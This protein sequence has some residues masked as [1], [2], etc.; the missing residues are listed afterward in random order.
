MAGRLTKAGIIMRELG[1]CGLDHVKDQ[2]RTIV[3]RGF[4]S[5]DPEI[6]RWLRKYS[7]QDCGPESA[8]NT[9]SLKDLV[10]DVLP[11]SVGLL[12]RQHCAGVDSL[13][14]LRLYFKIQ[15]MALATTR[16]S[17]E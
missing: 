7:G 1:R 2:W 16:S 15:E 11:A 4:C 17:K 9:R 6:G 12:E 5:M 8:K 10:K 14:H 13:L 3:Q